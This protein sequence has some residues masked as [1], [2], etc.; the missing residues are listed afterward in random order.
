MTSAYRLVFP[1]I[2]RIKRF[3]AQEK[4]CFWIDT[5][6][7]LEKKDGS[8]GDG[9]WIRFI[10]DDRAFAFKRVLSGKTTIE[11]HMDHGPDKKS[12]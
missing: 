5:L 10:M 7:R 11:D 6:T 2:S 3:K 12:G 4:G 1:R 8:S 9:A